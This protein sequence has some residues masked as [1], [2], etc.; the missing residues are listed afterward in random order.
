MLM[1]KCTAAESRT[2]QETGANTTK[3]C[4]FHHDIS[5]DRYIDTCHQ[6]T[7]INNARIANAAEIAG[8][9]RLALTF[10]QGM[11]CSS[12]GAC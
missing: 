5:R 4:F 3:A 1:R 9:F 10:Q 12:I 11:V 8:F 2:F 7:S 6:L